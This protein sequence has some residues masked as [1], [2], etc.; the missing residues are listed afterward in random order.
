MRF[1]E[2]RRRVPG[3][4][5]W[6]DRGE[7]QKDGPYQGPKVEQVVSG[8]AVAWEVQGQWNEGRMASG[9]A[10][11]SGPQPAAQTEPGPLTRCFCPLSERSEATST[12]SWP[13]LCGCDRNPRHQWDG[14]CGMG[15]LTLHL[16][17]MP[18]TPQPLKLGRD[19]DKLDTS[20]TC[21]SWPSVSSRA[22]AGTSSSTGLPSTL[23][24]SH[25][26]LSQQKGPL[27]WKPGVILEPLKSHQAFPVLLLT[28]QTL[29]IPFHPHVRGSSS[30]PI[31]LGTSTAS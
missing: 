17:A 25:L 8:G 9:A 11:G 28:F 18:S 21:M 30:R 23:V 1:E 22:S 15:L 3:Q 26:S 27:S 16:R 5:A 31:A 13:L 12:I 19:S 6:R 4:E 2:D 7:R 29:C 20:T 10:G 24:P 14:V